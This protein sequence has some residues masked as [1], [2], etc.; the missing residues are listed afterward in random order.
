VKLAQPV[1]LVLQALPVLGAIP[2]YREQ[3]GKR[4]PLVH[5]VKDLRYSKRLTVMHYCPQARIHF[6]QW[7]SLF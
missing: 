7:A 4:V 5:Q 2:V 1:L 6:Q 3:P